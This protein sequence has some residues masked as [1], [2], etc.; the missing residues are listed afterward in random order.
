MD[1]E[2]GLDRALE[3]TPEIEGEDSRFEIPEPE[4]RQE[5]NAT[6]VENFQSVADRLGRDPEAVLKGL[7]SELGTN[8]GIDESGR[9]RLTG[10]FDRGRVADA[11]EA[12]TEA[13]VLCP[14]CGLPDTGLGTERG[15]EVLRCD[16]CGA[17]SPTGD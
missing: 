1:Y 9:A 13:F 17:V 12:Y 5:G 14:E 6:V 3:R 2:D 4:V 10:A 16:A 8:A 11:I 7:Q 15:A